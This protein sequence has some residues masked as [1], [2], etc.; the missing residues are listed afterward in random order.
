MIPIHKL[1][2]LK[3]QYYFIFNKNF[4]F[5]FKKKLEPIFAGLTIC[6]NKSIPMKEWEK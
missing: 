3:F 6:P 2:N 1:C 4:Y 5:L